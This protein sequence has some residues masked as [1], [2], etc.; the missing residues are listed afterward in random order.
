MHGIAGAIGIGALALFFGSHVYAGFSNGF[1]IALAILGVSASSGS[2]TW[3]P[4]TP[5]R[6]PGRGRARV[7]GTASR[8]GYRSSS[9]RSRRLANRDRVDRHRL[10]ARHT[11]HPRK[12]MGAAPDALEFARAGIRHQPRLYRPSRAHRYGRSRSAA[13]RH[14]VH[15]R[16]PHRCPD[17]GRVHRAGNAG[18][19]HTRR[20]RAYLRRAFCPT[21]NLPAL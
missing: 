3:C 6:R 11:R 2:C 17:R 5:F 20:R 7:R 19:G 9:W 10:F 13:G 4:D 18:Q 14:R 16:A 15:R 8:S 12:C 21:S 1:V